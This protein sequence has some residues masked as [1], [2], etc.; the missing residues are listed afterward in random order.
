MPGHV[1]YL[2]RHHATGVF[3]I[4]GQTVPPSQG[5]AIIAC[6]IDRTDVELITGEDPFVIAGVAQYSVTTIQA[7][8]HHPALAALLTR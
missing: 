6:G 2:E 3:L 4:S 5:G 1:A 8:R 7:G